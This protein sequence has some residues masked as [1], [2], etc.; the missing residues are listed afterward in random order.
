MSFTTSG[1]L[2]MMLQMLA[3]NVVISRDQIS[4]T[5]DANESYQHQAYVPA[6]GT[7]SIQLDGVTAPTMMAIVCNADDAL[8][9]ATIGAAG[10]DTFYCSPIG[11]MSF[12]TGM[13]WEAAPL[14]M[15][16][17]NAGTQDVLVKIICIE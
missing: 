16:L 15:T 9:T 5:V 10:V 4:L 7:L 6:G 1:K 14:T 17:A 3:G 8:V 11:I 13:N 2:N 12:P